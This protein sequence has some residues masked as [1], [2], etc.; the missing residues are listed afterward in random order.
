M[1]PTVT[2][3]I[4]VPTTGS[5]TSTSP[6]SQNS[7][8]KVPLSQGNF[9]CVV[10]QTEVHRYDLLRLGFSHY[11]DYLVGCRSVIEART[12]QLRSMVLW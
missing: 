3:M 5:A 12:L 7:C 4:R 9:W 2:G 1:I 6:R 10:A 11:S 8:G